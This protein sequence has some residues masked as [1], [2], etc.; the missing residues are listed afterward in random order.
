MKR[1]RTSLFLLVAMTLSPAA[2]AAGGEAAQPSAPASTLDISYELYAGP[3]ALG[4][5]GVH[6][7]FQGSLYK[8]NST[9]QTGGIVNLFWRAKI[10]AQANGTLLNGHLNPA[11]YDSHSV[12]H[13]DKV[14]QVSL[15]YGPK[16]PPVLAA[17]PPYKTNKYPV[18]DEQKK[19]TLDPVSAVAFMTTG[20]SAGNKTPCGSIASVFDGARRYDVAVDYL[21]TANIRTYNGLY[22]G[23]AYVCQIHYRQIAGFKQKILSEGSRFPDIFAWV[24]SLPSRSNPA[25]HYLVPV[26]IWATTGFGNLTVTVSQLKI[27][28]TV[29]KG[30]M[31]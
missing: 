20:V 30:K 24:A 6:Q 19:G 4:K 1:A 12:N 31:N 9:L 17:N 18:S 26:R 15:T 5:V 27:D 25:Q 13:Q 22:D 8:A 23:P 10:D 3:F 11:L 14:Q 28:G 2:Y 21:R 29:L 16:G 7:M